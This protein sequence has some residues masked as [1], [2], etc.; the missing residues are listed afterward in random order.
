MHL[1]NDVLRKR[2]F[3]DEMKKIRLMLLDEYNE[4]EGTRNANTKIDYL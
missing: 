2:D 4:R 3:R 1:I